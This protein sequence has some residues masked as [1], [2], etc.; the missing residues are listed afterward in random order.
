[1]FTGRQ[2]LMDQLNSKRSYYLAVKKHYENSK[3]AYWIALTD[4]KMS[5]AALVDARKHYEWVQ[6]DMNKAALEME[7]FLRRYNKTVLTECY[8]DK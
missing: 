4:D 7:E 3:E 2:E 5:E 6:D 8:S 1:M